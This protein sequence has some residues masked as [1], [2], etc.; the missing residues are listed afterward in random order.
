MLENVVHKSIQTG[1]DYETMV[2]S[3][4]DEESAFSRIKISDLPA[5]WREISLYPKLQDLGS[6][7]YQNKESLILQVPSVI[8]PQEFNYVINVNHPEFKNMVTLIRQEEFLLD[9]RLY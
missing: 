5:N 7:W 2:I 8:I 3:I 1:L 6:K 9:S 4:A